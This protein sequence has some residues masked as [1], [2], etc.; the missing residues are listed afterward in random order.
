MQKSKF[1]V[2]SNG[3]TVEVLGTKFSVNSY[4]PGSVKTTLVQGSVR[5]TPNQASLRP[6]ILKPNQQVI[7]TTNDLIRRD[8]DASRVIAWKDGYFSFDGNNT[9][10]ILLEIGEWYGINVVFNKPLKKV[11][12]TGKIPK[13]INLS[14]LMML[15]EYQDIDVKAFKDKNNQLKLIVN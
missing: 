14:R 4:L 5:V 13:N 6:I 3:Q 9:Q 1:F 7:L 15:L 12:Y 10:E 8:V 11:K 2:E